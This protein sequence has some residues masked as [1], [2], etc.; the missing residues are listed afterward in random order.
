MALG[1]QYGPWWMTRPWVSEEPSGVAGVMDMTPEPGSYRAT[2]PDMS[3]SSS[4]GQGPG[5]FT[6]Y[7][8]QSG[9]DSGK[10]LGH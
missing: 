7:P 1:H 8:D 10:A 3:L 4:P 6:G 5:G 2:N 9:P